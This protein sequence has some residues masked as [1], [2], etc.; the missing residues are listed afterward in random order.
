MSVVEGSVSVGGQALACMLLGLSLRDL[1]GPAMPGLRVA[2]TCGL[3]TLIGRTVLILAGYQGAPV[4]VAAALPA[5]AA[6][7]WMEGS[8][9]TELIAKAFAPGVRVT[10]AAQTQS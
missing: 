3:C 4:L 5:I 8:K 7:A 2:A 6:Y 10:Q 9:V 1:F